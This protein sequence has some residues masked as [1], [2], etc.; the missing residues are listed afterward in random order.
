MQYMHFIRK[1]GIQTTSVLVSNTNH[2]SVELCSLWCISY[3]SLLK[4]WHVL[5]TFHGKQNRSSLLSS[6]DI[7]SLEQ[8][9]GDFFFF[10]CGRAKGVSNNK[11]CW[12]LLQTLE[13]EGKT[14]KIN[15]HRLY[16]LLHLIY[17]LISKHSNWVETSYYCWISFILDDIL[18]QI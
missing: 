14:D 17:C 10:C 12:I 16:F 3:Y 11:F 9:C 6:K 15:I 18:L 2:M 4:F 8:A 1:W 5:I 13:K 7:F